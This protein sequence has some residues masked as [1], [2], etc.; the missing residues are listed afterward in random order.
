MGIILMFDKREREREREREQSFKQQI[1]PPMY[2]II[3]KVLVK[4]SFQEIVA[5]KYAFQPI[6]FP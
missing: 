3:F 6:G 5:L 2:L 1:I 4:F